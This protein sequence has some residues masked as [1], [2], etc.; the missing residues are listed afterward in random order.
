[1]L[2]SL[3]MQKRGISAVVATI[4]IIL[5][6][7]A[8]IV[9][10]WTMIV[11]MLKENIEGNEACLNADISVDESSGWTC[12]DID[13]EISSVKIKRGALGDDIEK[14]KVVFVYEGESYT[15]VV[16]A[17]GKNQALTYYFHFSYVPDEIKVAPIVAVGGSFKE[18]DI[19]A[20]MKPGSCSLATVPDAGDVLE[21]DG[22][23]AVEC[24][25][26]GDCTPG[27]CEENPECIN[28]ECV[29]DDITSCSNDD[30]CCPSGCDSDTDNDCDCVAETC[31]SLG[32]ECDSWDDGCG[33]VVDCGPCSGS[34]VCVDGVCE[35][36][37]ELSACTDITEPGNYVV[38]GNIDE[39]ERNC[40]NIEAND[41]VLDCQGNR[42]RG[43]ASKWGINAYKSG[44]TLQNI[45]IKNCVVEGFGWG[46]RVVNVNNVEVTGSQIEIP[47]TLG[48]LYGMYLSGDNIIVR[49]NRIYAETPYHGN[50][51]IRNAGDG[52]NIIEYNNITHTYEGIKCYTGYKTIRYNNIEDV[53]QEGIYMACNSACSGNLI[54]GNNITTSKYGLE[55]TYVANSDILNNIF[56]DSREAYDITCSSNVGSNILFE[57]NICD[58]GDSNDCPGHDCS[59][60]ECS[61]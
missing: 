36:A 13:E 59:A 27:A 48:T 10:I 6:T 50:S 55:L 20:I 12:S 3:G 30:G 33:D 21:L 51:G 15:K 45:E 19:R 9:I 8:G 22:E 32:Y 38:T 41:V 57:G 56:C 58:A 7:I 34:E 46:I 35:T 60:G 17:P 24:E 54:E 39:Y 11:P 37:I 43:D 14:V 28:N 26:A 5:I 23:E 31:A 1:M 53:F 25:D 52:T 61:A 47:T 49:S 2:R 18:C 42:L 44:E 16:D 29:Y 40:F 4:L